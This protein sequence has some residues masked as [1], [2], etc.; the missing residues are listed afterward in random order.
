MTEQRDA[1]RNLEEDLDGTA[2]GLEFIG[3]KKKKR[4]KGKK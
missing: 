4:K 1:K 2:A 3:G